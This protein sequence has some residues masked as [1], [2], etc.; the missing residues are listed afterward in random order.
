MFSFLTTNSIRT[1]ISHL[2][3][4]T[5]DDGRSS[6]EFKSPDDRYL[7]INRLPPAASDQDVLHGRV[8]NKANCSLAP[9]LHW[10]LRQEET[11]HVVEGTA[12]F[13]IG[14]KERLA[15]TGE[16]V[17]IPKRQIHT[18]CNANE[19]SGLVVE[20]VLDPGVIQGKR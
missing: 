17:V 7:V 18:F 13:N 16:V 9:P 15:Q 20:F 2:D 6:V 11:F 10:H 12:K 19:E 3:S 1:K 8:P 5:L 14:G 4:I